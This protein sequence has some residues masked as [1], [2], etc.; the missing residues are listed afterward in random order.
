[1]NPGWLG[2]A[3]PVE[4]AAFAS[5]QQRRHIDR[6]GNHAIEHAADLVGGGRILP[7]E[8]FRIRKLEHVEHETVGRRHR[9]AAQNVH[10]EVV[11]HSG[12]VGEQIRL[13]ERDD[14]QLPDGVSVLQDRVHLV[15]VDAPCEPNVPIDRRES[16]QRDV[17]AR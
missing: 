17:A 5:T 15:A 1:M 3:A 13:V 2:Y 4:Q 9:L 12:H 11:Q 8:R 10:P 6:A 16:E 7:K 14:R